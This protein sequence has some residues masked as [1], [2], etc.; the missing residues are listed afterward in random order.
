MKCELKKNNG[1]LSIY[2]DGE[3]YA[4]VSFKSFRPTKK[5][6]TDFYSAGIRLFNILSSGI[7][8]AVGV[9][10]SLYGESWI[11]EYTYDF[12]P[13]DRQI[14]LFTE[15]APEAYFALMLQLDTRPWWLKKYT[16]YP[17][18][19]RK[20]A[21]ME[22]DPRWRAAASAYMQAVLRHVEEKYGDRFYGY[23]LLAGTTTEWLSDNSFEDASPISEAAYKVW[24]KDPSALIPAKECRETDEK[25]VFLDCC[26]DENLIQ[27][28]KFGSWQRADTI[29]YF[30]K[31]A[32]E[33]LQH[34][35][36]LGLYFGY[37]F[38][39]DGSR[40]WNTGHLDYER[41]FLS[42]DIDMFS[43]PVSYA[44]RA[45]DCGS[46][47][48]LT[49]QTLAANNKLYFIEHDQT[50][51][52]VPDIIE[53]QY[54]VHPNKVKTIE[55]DI[56]LLRRDFLLAAASGCA[57]WWF[58]MFEG[59]F[60]N[61]TLMNEITEMIRASKLLL[62]AGYRSVSEIAIIA[63]P[64]SMYF[65]NKNSG[66]NTILFGKQRGELSLIGA[67]YDIFSS[68]D[69]ANMDT[70]QYKLFIFLDQFKA[71]PAVDAFIAA[72]K[73]AGKSLL[74]IYAYN[75][76]DAEYNTA[77]MSRALGFN[78][79]KN[80]CHEDT[81]C[82]CSGSSWKVCAPRPCF[83]VTE[84]ITVLGRYQNSKKAAFG[85]K[86]EKNGLIAFS[87][88]GTVS[89]TALTLLLKEAGVHQYTASGDAVIYANHAMLGIYH[90]LE[91]DTNLLL[92]HDDVFVDLFNGGQEYSSK[93]CRLV[94][95]YAR[96]RAKLLIKKEYIK[97]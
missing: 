8:S 47:Q 20:M 35:K 26:K 22:A 82:L 58:D 24:R 19:F 62:S 15:N 43:S 39:L 75:I 50:T 16:G 5:N 79:T 17:D 32:Q 91:S 78:V 77:Q 74:F 59:W 73:A 65:V 33:I 21:Q 12:T 60:Y 94:V 97:T 49:S 45:Q 52:I 37:I 89:Y 11:D 42:E 53:G 84:D 9:P 25:I 72:L 51:C 23:F 67:P 44:Y 80:P 3:A 54:F 70:A 95:P 28:R 87:G 81:I 36:L 13:I 41:V 29:L 85:Y 61:E 10:Y 4:P 92:P 90:I 48:M 57:M 56:N 38:E 2:I 83:A 63:D 27:Y 14:A 71:N 30:A 7:I 93:G 55:E 69:V 46:H 96:Q 40:L 64:E 18:S 1:M 34:K 6:I 88:L 86:K 76:L 66:M 68:C 31:K